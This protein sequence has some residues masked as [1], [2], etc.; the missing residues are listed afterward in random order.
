MNLRGEH[1]KGCKEKEDKGIYIT[2]FSF[3][4]ILKVCKVSDSACLIP[5]THT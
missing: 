2:L 4:N 1:G 3:F 5:S